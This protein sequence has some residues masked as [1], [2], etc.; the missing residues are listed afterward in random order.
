MYKFMPLAAIICI[1]STSQALGAEQT[2][3]QEACKSDISAYCSDVEMGEGRVLKCLK[4]N[5]DK[6]SEECKT[7]LK[8]VI[9]NKQSG[10][11]SKPQE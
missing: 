5:R 8:K 4:E 7:A 9:R 6:L 11:G 2:S 3:P 1:L 10:K